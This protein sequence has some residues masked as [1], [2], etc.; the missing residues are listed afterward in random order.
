MDCCTDSSIVEQ[1]RLVWLDAHLDKSNEN[2]YLLNYFRRVMKNIDIFTNSEKCIDFLSQIINEQVFMIV[3]GSLGQNIVPRIHD[4]QQL[5]SIY[6]YCTNESRHE[7]WT[8][9]WSKVKGIFTKIDSIRI[10]LQRAKRQLNQN[11]IEIS[12]ISINETT[13]QDVHEL[14]PSF[15]YTQL[16]KEI[17]MEINDENDTRA[18]EEL[19]VYCHNLYA[20]NKVELNNIDQ[21]VREYHDHTPIWWYTYEC[22]LYPM[23]NRSLRMLEVNVILKIGFFL[24]H[25]HHHIEQLHKEQ[26]DEHH[27][28]F[29]VYRGQGLSKA[30]FDK[31]FGRK[32]GLL[33][34]NNFLST[35]MERKISE[36]FALCALS[37]PDFVGILYVM[38][39][40]PAVSSA[41]FALVNDVSYYKD[42]EQEILFSMNTIFRISQIEQIDGNDRLWE[43][44]LILTADNDPGLSNLLERIRDETQ[45][46]TG[47]LRLCRLLMK[48]NQT[49]KAEQV[50]KALLEQNPADPMNGYYYQQLGC[51]KYQQGEYQHAISYYENALE[52][53]L[54]Y[55]PS[56]HSHVATSY[57]SIGAA[58]FGMGDYTKAVSFYEKSIEIRQETGPLN[59]PSLVSPY[60]NMAIVHTKMGEYFKAISYY[61]KCLDIEEKILPANHPDLAL[62][63]NN[64]GGVYDCMKDYLQSLSFYEKALKIRQKSLPENHPDIAESYSNIG[65]I[66]TNMDEYAKALESQ[67]KALQIRQN[68]L[69][70]NHPDL[71]VSYNS[72]AQVYGKMGETSDALAYYNKALEIRRKIFPSNHPDLATSYND[73]GV[74]YGNM[75]EY[76][77]A[78]S[79]FEIAVQMA[80]LSLPPNHPD[81]QQF[82]QSL[83]Y[84][85]RKL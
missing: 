5:N 40:D 66:Y 71:A 48:L 44:K 85:R 45:G 72:I 41:P 49:E 76:S 37:N 65:A 39:V 80:E 55:L 28:P 69:P 23:L 16:L 26:S 56:N 34:F 75:G 32:G 4:M 22:F 12:F 38:T 73:I 83:E 19:S 30:N 50:Y 53:F 7:K 11:S 79:Y 64:I 78:I 81:L 68:S 43:V 10:A 25:L 14:E 67:E 59:Y 9:N 2:V 27:I 70:P 3:S 82:R 60:N 51:V 8:C 24:R 13:V 52:I 62:S 21:F 15:M 74:L 77:K 63:Y 58:Y 31:L 33:A 6:V 35:S 61:Q 47:W 20:D 18:I 46:A 17:L 36:N 1:F 42:T 57:N 54:K 29:T 84:V